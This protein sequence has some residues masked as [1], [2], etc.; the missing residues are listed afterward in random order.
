VLRFYLRRLFEKRVFIVKLTTDRTLDALAPA[1]CS[2]AR[3]LILEAERLRTRHERANRRR[4]ARLLRD[5]D[6]IEVTMTLTDEVMR[7]SSLPSAA[8]ILRGAARRSSVAGFGLINAVGLR[9][10]SLVSRLMPATAVKVVH[11]QVR[12]LSRDL[13]LA[14]E[15]GPLQ[16]HL[17][18]RER[19]GIHLNINVLGEAVLGEREANERFDRVLEMMR[20]AR[21]NYISVKLSSVVS[22]LTM[23]DHEGSLGRVS[24]KLRLLYRSA[25]RESVFVNLDMEEFRDLRLTVDAFR[26]VLSETEFEALDA[27]LV[28][29]AYLPD[30]HEAVEE[31]V[32]WAKARFARRGGRV[33]IRLVKG[34]NLAME[35]AEAQLHGWT[36]APYGSKADVDASFLRLVDLC[37]RSEHGAAL[38]VGVASHNLFD[39]SWALDVAEQRGVLDQLDI[40]MLEGMACAEA[41]AIVKSGRNVLLYAPVTRHDDF[42]AAVA[43]LVRRLDE[44]TSDENYLKAAFYIAQDPKV[45]DHQQARFLDSVQQRHQVATASRRHAPAPISTHE[46][47]ENSA[48]GDPTNPTY[49]H[50]VTGA[51]AR[52]GSLE[53]RQ[54][55]LVINALEIAGEQY[56]EGCDPS[57]HGATWYRYSVATK[58]QI[59][60]AVECAR[61]AGPGWAAL[62]CEER[63]QILIRAANVMELRRAATIA[64]MARDGGK[65]VSEADPEVSEAIDF[66]RYYPSRVR[67]DDTATPLGVVLVVPPWNFPYAIPSG[68]VCA[69]LAAGNSVILKPAPETVATA[70]ELVR[71]L[72]EGGVPK[73]VL[74]FLPTRH[75]ETGRH[76][77]S[78]NGVDGVILT[79]SFET[80]KLFT[81]WKPDLN[82]LAETSGKNAMLISSYADIDLAV[83]DLVQSAFGHAGQKCSAASLAIVDQSVL[84]DPAFFRQLSDAV[85]SLQVG[86]GYQ[87][88]TTVGPI[89][90]RAESPLRRALTQL[91]PG[92]TWLVKPEPLDEAELMWR[93]GVKLGVQPGSWSHRNE[94]FGPVLAVMRAP[95]FATA[96]KW[97]NQVPYGLTAGLHSLDEGECQYWMDHVEAGNLYLNRGVTG[98]VVN[99][100]PFGGWKRSSVGPTAKAGGPNYVN[101]LRRWAPLYEVESAVSGLTTWWRGFGSKARDES[102]LSVEVNMQRYRHHLAPIAVRIDDSF[103]SNAV[104]YLASVATLTGA[105]IAFSAKSDI[106]GVVDLTIESVDA[107]LERCATFDKVRWLSK[108]S[109]PAVAL[110]AEGISTDRRPLAQAGAIEGP[111]WLSEQ[112]VAMTRHRYGNVNAGPKPHCGGLGETGPARN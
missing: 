102:G 77:V 104:S 62:G 91:D 34:A 14:S 107:L 27:G 90:R 46:I 83:K 54:I 26:S 10:V 50:E 93:P 68:G 112:S 3:Q 36:P 66:A 100:Q 31:L 1:S 105:S 110:L 97:Q 76:L 2:R 22:Q 89:I 106:E 61:A 109:A 88:A 85:E 52:V 33:K 80:A 103:D 8:G 94:W 39:L 15:S 21:V 60:R 67:D 16:R 59:D 28:L 44:N 99:R 73:D 38:R 86:P 7:V 45:F 51:L 82:L 63:R 6:A 29:Q 42:A 35:H 75:D 23:I 55:P 53:V 11:A 101:C 48:D 108:E 69:A 92:E 12:R 5:R 57:D 72:W 96:L 98:A 49:V 47:F 95:D 81:S 40:E 111:R 4:F 65:T 32:M 24:E 71:Q 13:I 9:L 41:L 43:Y 70:W 19:E 56:E 30:S 17:D 87:L 78:H 37:L 18:S 84:E 20:R 25:Q 74:Q 64:V 58:E 79:G